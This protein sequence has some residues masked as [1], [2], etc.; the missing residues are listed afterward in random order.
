MPGASCPPASSATGEIP[1]NVSCLCSPVEASQECKSTSLSLVGFLSHSSSLPLPSGRKSFSSVKQQQYSWVG[2]ALVQVCFGTSLSPDQIWKMPLLD[3]G[4][5]LAVNAWICSSG[6]QQFLWGGLLE[7]LSVCICG[8]MFPPIA[9]N[10]L[11]LFYPFCVLIVMCS[12]EVLLWSCLFGVLNPSCTWMPI[13]LGLGNRL[14]FYWIDSLCL[15][16]DFCMDPYH[17][18]LIISECSWNLLSGSF[19]YLF[20]F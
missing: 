17:G 12:G 9:L 20:S 19:I 14:K 13:L 18:I 3:V 10:V 6:L 11:T 5:W 4:T 1:H 7:F 16:I 8:L 2:V 15:F